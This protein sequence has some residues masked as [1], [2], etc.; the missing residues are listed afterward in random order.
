MV[1]RPGKPGRPILLGSSPLCGIG[2]HDRQGRRAIV[3]P[4]L[5]IRAVPGMGQILS[6]SPNAGEAPIPGADGCLRDRR[7]V[8]PEE[9]NG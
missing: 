7:S 1:G 9:A 5:K 6:S 3:T 4:G 2:G 8:R